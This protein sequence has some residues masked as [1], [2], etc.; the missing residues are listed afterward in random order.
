MKSRSI[1]RRAPWRKRPPSDKQLA[2]LRKMKGLGEDSD[3]ATNAAAS[4]VVAGHRIQL[5]RM[6]GGQ[7]RLTVL[8]VPR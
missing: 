5:G 8:V 3:E 7:V 1:S 6:N 4:I 2:A